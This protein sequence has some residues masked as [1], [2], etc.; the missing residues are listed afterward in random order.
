[1]KL[2]GK[3]ILL[4]SVFFVLFNCASTDNLRFPETPKDELTK[5]IDFLVTDPNLF[6]AQ[7]G[8]FIES[9]NDGR[10]IYRSN[11]HKSFIP[12]SNMKLYT[13]ACAL[14]NLK[15][16]FK[17]KTSFYTIDKPSGGELASDLIIRGSGD[18]GISGRFR[19]DDMYAC[20]KDWAD[21]LKK[22][23]IYK[24]TGNLVGDISLFGGPEVRAGWEWDDMPY[25]YAAQISALSFNDNCVD[26]LIS[27]GKDIGDSVTIKTQPDIDYIKIINTVK[28]VH[29][30][31]L[32][33]LNI[34]RERGRN[35]V[36]VSGSVHAGSEIK[37][38]YVT[39]ENP[40]LLLLKTFAKVLKENGIEFDGELCINEDKSK[41]RYDSLNVLFEYPSQPLS[42]LIEVVNKNS[43]N[44]FAEQL[45]SVLGLVNFEDGSQKNGVKTVSRL[46]NSMGIPPGEINIVDGSGL[47][48]QNLVSPFS[49][50]SVLRTMYKSSVFD[51]FFN[52]LPIAGV[53]GTLKNRMKK[54]P[55]ENN[56]HAKTG[57]VANTR[58]LSGYAKDADGKNY[59]FSMMFNNYLVPTA[60]IN[61]LQDKICILLSTYHSGT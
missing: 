34:W 56:V 7:V 12:A 1:M 49:T 52:S 8:I 4:F 15:P 13:T 35:V 17:L 23:G 38:D 3:S 36:Y 32:T 19:D 26:L 48:R 29:P 43:N 51:D 21:S 60:Y 11:E 5:E 45:F 31:S 41:F 47:A 33:D 57:Y 46:L 22:D 44:F 28:T 24:L 27:P 59:A 30:D 40:A 18:P 39:V 50:V 20:L 53:D 14:R 55:A 16:D 6:N 10:V 42:K 2:S 61:D 25:Y 58:S 54:S 9:L 37:R